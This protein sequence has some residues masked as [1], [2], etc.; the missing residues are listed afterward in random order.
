MYQFNRLNKSAVSNLKHFN[1]L[2]SKYSG[3]FNS[4]LAKMGKWELEKSKYLNMEKDLKRNLYTKPHLSLNDIPT[5]KEYGQKQDLSVAI[6]KLQ[7][8][9]IDQQKNEQL[10]NKISLFSGDI[11]TLEV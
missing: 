9:R 3:I 11:T 4:T 10:A 7:T 5:W 1:S 2:I 6:S 8:V